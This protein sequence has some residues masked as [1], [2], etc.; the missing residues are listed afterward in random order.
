MLNKKEERYIESEIQ[1]ITSYLRRDSGGPGLNQFSELTAHIYLSSW[2]GGSNRE[3]L[4]DYDIVRII[5][6]STEKKPRSLIDTYQ[7]LNIEHKVLPLMNNPDEDI[8]KYF[9]LVYI[10]IHKSVEN[11]ENIL[12]HCQ[13][14]QSLSASFVIYYYLKRYYMTNFGKDVKKDYDMV[15]PQ[16]FYLLDIIKFVKQY[17]PCVEPNAEFIH[18]LLM[19]EMFIKKRLRQYIEV[20]LEAEKKHKRERAKREAEKRRKEREKEKK[21]PVK[22]PEKPR[23]KLEYDES[24]D[25]Y[26]E[27]FLS[28]SSE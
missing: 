26:S 20:Q 23:K 19:A 10:E 27:S 15:D 16:N 24:S 9:E 17:R 12:I 21:E 28:E 13:S 25:D 4:K 3:A 18:Q 7:V 2:V 11:D 22:N 5:C 1:N 8:S 6:L 14:G